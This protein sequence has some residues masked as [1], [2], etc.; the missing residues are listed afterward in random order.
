MHEVIVFQFENTNNGQRFNS[1]FILYN[2]T[3]IVDT[4]KVCARA[5]LVY[6]FGKNKLQK[7]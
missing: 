1:L 7:Y 3:H 4:A 6:D 5:P 2:F